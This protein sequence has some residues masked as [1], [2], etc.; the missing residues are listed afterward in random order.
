VVDSNP[1]FLFFT[2]AATNKFIQKVLQRHSGDD[3]SQ[4][5]GTRLEDC[6]D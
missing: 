4:I 5:L 6:V 2:M 3:K 1:Y